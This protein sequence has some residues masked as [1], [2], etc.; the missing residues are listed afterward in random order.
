MSIELQLSSV[1]LY[2]LAG[3]IFL[4]ALFVW[5]RIIVPGLPGTKKKNAQPKTQVQTALLCASVW[6]YLHC[7]GLHMDNQY[8]FGCF[9]FLKCVSF[10][11]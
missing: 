6:K 10:S 4:C 7:I 8:V 11:Q 9:P 2:L 5:F 1:D 3:F